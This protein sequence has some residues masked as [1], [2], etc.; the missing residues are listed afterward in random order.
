MDDID[1]ALRVVEEEG[2]FSLPEFGNSLLA[3]SFWKRYDEIPE[4]VS[5]QASQRA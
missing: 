1:P 2:Q 3:L 4:E 5:P